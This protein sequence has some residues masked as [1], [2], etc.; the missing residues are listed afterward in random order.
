MVYL[1]DGTFEGVLSGIYKMFHCKAKR[2]EG[3]LWPNA[4][5]QQTFFTLTMPL[6]TNR[7]D[8]YTVAMSIYDTFGNDGFK[9]VYYAY[10]AEDDSYGT[11]LFRALK[12]AY[13]IGR[14]AFEALQDP[15]ILKLYKMSTKVSREAHL[16][17]GLIRFA[18]LENGLYYTDFEPTQ[19]ILAVL[20]PHFSE[21][22]KDQSW[23]IH[24]KKRGIAAF[25][26]QTAYVINAVEKMPEIVYSKRENDF[27][28]LW[29]KY[30]HHI[31]IEA[32]KN[33]RCQMQHMPKKYWAFLTEKKT[34][35]YHDK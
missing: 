21:R 28:A 29:Q 4:T 24:D 26:D 27:Q 33:L 7:E 11:V 13:K 30:V 18:E 22:F 12:I 9:C 35:V 5:Y 25:Y 2:N 31:S 8:A 32:R 19:N 34:N 3:E 10:L 20:A 1:H 6:E 17:L 23:V 14:N 15:D 16:F